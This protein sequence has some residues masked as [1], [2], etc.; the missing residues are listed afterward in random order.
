M[1]HDTSF[2]NPAAAYRALVRLRRL[3]APVRRLRAAA[4][5]PGDVLVVG[6]GAGGP[7]HVMLVGAR[8]NNVWHSTAA[9]GWAQC[10][11]A[12]GQGFERLFGAYR[13]DDRHRWLR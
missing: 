13:L 11:W 7:G 10:G 12:L 8:E 2:H 1:P 9:S 5:Q 4:Y 6:T 3:Y